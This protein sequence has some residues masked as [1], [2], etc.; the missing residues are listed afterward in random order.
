MKFKQS[1]I[2]IITSFLL[3]YLIIF[4]FNQ[5]K[6]WLLIVPF[7][8]YILFFISLNYLNRKQKK[9]PSLF[10]S[11]YLA[12]TMIRLLLLVTTIVILFIYMKEKYLI[13]SLFFVNYIIFSIF[14][15][16]KFLS[17]NEKSL[18]K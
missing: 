15:V 11:A 6:E 16:F 1:A 7:Y 4:L 9:S 10:I 12:I 17:K 3:S 18:L 5:G 8:F 14:E 13:V 2:L